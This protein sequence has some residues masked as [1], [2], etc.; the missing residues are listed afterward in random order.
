MSGVYER[1]LMAHH[2]VDVSWFSY[3]SKWI[4]EFSCRRAN[5]ESRI[6]SDSWNW[7]S[8]RVTYTCVTCCV[9][10]VM[11]Q[12]TFR[13]LYLRVAEVWK[14]WHQKSLQ[15]T[16]TAS[17]SHCKEK[18]L[19]TWCN[20]QSAQRGGTARNNHCKEQSLQGAVTAKN[21]HKEQPLQRRVTAMISRL[22][23]S[24]LAKLQGSRLQGLLSK[25]ALGCTFDIANI[26]SNN[27]S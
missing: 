5:L 20:E 4:M 27:D 10:W 9:K 23:G 21:S 22:Q 14:H 17:N 15:W 1:K 13:T 3:A 6:F 7:G 8:H 19:K 16:V 24:R 18:P 12:R 2:L 11:F 26:C 25:C